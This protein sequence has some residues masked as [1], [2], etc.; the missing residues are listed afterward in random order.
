M[1]QCLHGMAIV[2]TPS[3]KERYFSGMPLDQNPN[4]ALP[5]EV[6]PEMRRRAIMLVVALSALGLGVV[7]GLSISPAAHEES[8]QTIAELEG[9]LKLA[10]KR[11]AELTRTVTYAR[12]AKSQSAQGLLKKADRRRHLD[13]GKRYAKALKGAKAQTASELIEWFVKRWNELLDHPQDDDRVGRRAQALSRLV[14]GMARNLDPGD[15]VPWQAEFLSGKWL[16]DLHF[17]LDGDGFPGKRS[18]KNPKDGFN[19]QSVCHVA[20]ALNL[21][22]LDAQIMVL[23]NMRCDSPKSK[24]SVFLQGRTRNQ[25]LDAFI[26]ALREEGFLVKDRTQRGNRLILIGKPK[27]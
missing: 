23:P 14:G 4:Q 7:I 1:L 6:T 18:K 12:H 21:T 13:F 2:K 17:D 27:S 24:I 20:M 5:G 22:N 10:R 9:E 25:A 15:Y 8:E 16:G 3:K 11:I 26:T 19:N